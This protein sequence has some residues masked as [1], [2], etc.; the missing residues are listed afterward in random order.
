MVTQAHWEEDERS[1]EREDSD[2]LPE[3]LGL[4]LFILKPQAIPVRAFALCG[5]MCMYCTSFYLI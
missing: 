5:T 1:N 4:Y 3:P 2:A